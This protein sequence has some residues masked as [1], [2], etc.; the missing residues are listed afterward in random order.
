MDPSNCYDDAARAAAYAKLDFPGTYYLAY[1]DLPEL[2]A[3]HVAGTRALDFG[4]GTGRSTRFLRQ[5]GFD[6]IGVDVAEPMI[7]RA[8]AL[9]PHGVYRRIEEH[10]LDRLNAGAFDLVAAL[11]TFDNIPTGESKA[12]AMRGIRR[13][14]S[15]NGRFV[16]VVSSPELYTH[17]WA[18]FST[19]DFPENRAAKSGDVV[20]C[21]NVALEPLGL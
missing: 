4:C 7:A 9:D 13:L 17:E 11:F 8:R 21:V 10:G 2:L 14:L 12:R 16:N 1:R 15:P 3:R 19:L 6:A 18:S 20:R 5:H